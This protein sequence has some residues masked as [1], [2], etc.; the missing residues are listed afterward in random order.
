MFLIPHTH[1]HTSWHFNFIHYS[2]ITWSS[3]LL[4]NLILEIKCFRHLGTKPWSSQYKNKGLL[5]SHEKM[6]NSTKRQSCSFIYIFTCHRTFYI[7]RH[8]EFINCC[9]GIG[10]CSRIH[11]T[12]ISLSLAWVTRSPRLYFVQPRFAHIFILF[13]QRCAVQWSFQALT[14][15]YLVV[16]AFVALA[17]AGKYIKLVFI[18]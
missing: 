14:M 18:Y 5:Q 8:Y 3:C 15:K 2:K 1:T 7:R 12:Q 9:W 11:L 16:L 4:I 13:C 17:S 10:Q 6:T